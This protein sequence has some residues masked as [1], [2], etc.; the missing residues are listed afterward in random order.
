MF[1]LMLKNDFLLFFR[2]GSGGVNTWVFFGVVCLLL[3]LA[4]PLARG[5]LQQVAVGWFWVAM[6]F[7]NILA[8]E[9][10]FK[11]EFASGSIEQW[12]LS[13]YPLAVLVGAKMLVHWVMTMLPLI[14]ITPFLGMAF[15]LSGSALVVSLLLGTP[16]LSSL[17]AIGAALVLGVCEGGLL[18]S[19]ILLP[20]YVPVLIFGVGHQDLFLASLLLL[21]LGLTPL[22]VAALLR[23][24]VEGS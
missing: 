8:A 1:W 15:H 11:S 2:R 19:I 21:S 20:L 3:P 22:C 18:L 4:L 24:S 13:P 6:L 14:M 16:V 23:I 7:A 17:A 9:S 12:V 5:V 10:L